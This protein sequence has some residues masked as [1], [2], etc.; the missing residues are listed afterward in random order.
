MLWE[1]FQLIIPPYMKP[2]NSQSKASVV[3]SVT[4]VPYIDLI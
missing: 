2:I 4:K 1:K 3:C